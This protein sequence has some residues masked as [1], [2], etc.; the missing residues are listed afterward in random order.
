MNPFEVAMWRAEADPTLRSGM[1][2]LEEL[3]VVPNWDRLVAAHEWAVR[4]VPRFQQ[5]VVEPPLGVAAPRWT[6]DPGFDLRYHLR[7]QRLPEGGG[8]PELLDVA[9]QLIMTPFDRTRAPWEAVLVEGLPGGHAAYLLK[10]HHSATDGLGGVQLLGQLHSRTREPD[11]SKPQPPP[12]TPDS[13]GTLGAVLSQLRGDIEQASGLLRGAGAGALRAVTQP[14]GTL[15]ALT[16]YGRSLR[17]VLTPPE[18]DGS[19]LLVRRSHISRFAALDVSFA[20][21]RTAAKAAG[22]SLNDAYL[23]ALLGGYRRYHEAMA[24]AVPEAI[25]LAIPISVRKPGDPEG[26]NRIASARIAGP[27]RIVDPRARIEEVRS[28]VLNARGEPA[29]DL[30]SLVFP[31]LSRLPGPVIA[32]LAGPMTKGNDLQASNVPGLREPRYLAGAE[33]VRS[34]PYAPLPGCAAMITLLTHGDTA[35][36]GVHFD[37]GS[38]TEADLFV[39]CLAEGFAEVLSLI[40]D[41][42]DPLIRAER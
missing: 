20:H 35:C 18:A 30:I 13:T 39:R 34:Y 42:P 19:P 40:D 2:A 23:A 15:N 31:A 5:R 17:R 6:L 9:A 24:V 4:M 7:R 29:A 41:A 25:P 22:G 1:V 33:I 32:E 27:L 3:D 26:G 36:V 38:F 28:I 10:L 11:P 16:R 21:L 8:W 14:R 12:P 37:A